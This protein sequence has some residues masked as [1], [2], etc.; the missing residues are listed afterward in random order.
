MTYVLAWNASPDP[1]AGMR[2]VPPKK[3]VVMGERLA[4]GRRVPAHWVREESDHPGNC[5]YCRVRV[6][7]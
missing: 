4:C 2:D 3:H 1:R 6:G 5:I 7:R